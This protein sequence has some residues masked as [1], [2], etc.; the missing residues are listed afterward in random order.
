M[1]KRFFE[2]SAAGTVAGTDLLLISQPSSTVVY[3]AS[4]L[5]AAASDNSLNDSAAQFLAEGF[6]AGKTIDIA[7]FTGAVGNNNFA[8]VLSAAAGKLVLAGITLADDAAGE[9]VTIGQWDT[10]RAE[11]QDFSGSGDVSAAANL[12]DNAIVRGDGG[13]KGVQTSGV[14]IGAADEISGY[15]AKLNLQTGTTYAIDVAGS[16]TDSGK[17]IDHSNASAITVT[18]PNSAPVGFACTYVQ[19]GAGQITF[20]PAS[21]ANLRNRQAHTKSA[22]QYAQMSLYVRSNAGGAAAEWVLGG[23]TAL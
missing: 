18:L 13:V 8:V 20:S 10:K 4:T 7:G 12:T 6:T 11:A 23:D 19:A 1:S 9:S 2:F 16:D 15:L 21:G 17:I 22:G 5:S 14:I 3:T